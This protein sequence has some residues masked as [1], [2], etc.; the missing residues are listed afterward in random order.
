MLEIFLHYIIFFIIIFSNG[1]LFKKAFI[2]KNTITLNF[3]EQSILGLITTGFIA[4][5]LNFFIPLNNLVVYLNLIL[6]LFFIYYYKSEIKFGFNKNSKIFIL[7]VFLLSL[8]GIY[9]SGFSDDLGHYHGGYITNTDNSNYII[10]A[11][12]LHH[13]YGYSSIWLILHAYLNFNG[14]LLQD[15]HILNGLIFFLIISY[16]LTENFE[17]KNNR[18]KN[19]LYLLYS[20]LI[21]FLLIKYTRLKEFGLDRPGVLIYCFL[22]YFSAKYQYLLKKSFKEKEIF[23]FILL[24]ICLFITATKIF[25]LSCFL[26]PF[27]F[28]I[29]TKFYECFFKKLNLIFFFLVFSFFLKNILISGCLIYPFSFSCIS[30][31][32]WNSKDIASQLLL[33]TEASTKSFDQFKGYLSISEYISSF[34]WLNTWIFRNIEE[35]NNYFLTSFLVLILFFISSKLKKIK[36]RFS[37]LEII[38][39]IL[40]LVNLI[41][42]IKSPVVRY[43]HILFILFILSIVIV[44]RREF[45]KK[46]FFFNII[47]LILF[48]FNFSKNFHRLYKDNFYN[49]PY[50]HIKTIN[51]Y[52]YPLKKEIDSFIYYSGW[53]DAYPVGNMILDEF[54][55]KRILWF[56]VIYK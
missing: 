56:D 48:S 23:F 25:L 36:I 26:I 54:K 7:L 27:L 50:E 35:F 4:L 28:I 16:F 44:F 51:W 31:L 24:L 6:G 30:D 55:H 46:I 22:I 53:I 13:H 40:F 20:V 38:I 52:R 37:F 39:L 9:G 42:F 8:I 14:S 41:I 34:N 1:F 29:K 12:F 3:F 15:I 19:F 33:L 21:F 10:G 18:Y 43:H 11:N 47:L 32:S 5:L 17:K 2:S 45:I 49:N